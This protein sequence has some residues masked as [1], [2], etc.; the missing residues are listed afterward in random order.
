MPRSP[1]HC[2]GMS[3]DGCEG[4]SCGTGLRDRSSAATCGL[5]AIKRCEHGENGILIDRIAGER[6]RRVGSKKGF[7]FLN[8]CRRW[9]PIY[10]A[11]PMVLAIR[12]YEVLAIGLD[13]H[14]GIAA[15]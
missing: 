13:K 10:L 7:R 11:I 6:K 4:R 9:S 14:C 2:E 1:S 5:V 15:P 8:Q 12:C 3:Y